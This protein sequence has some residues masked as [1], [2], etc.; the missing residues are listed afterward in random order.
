[1]PLNFHMHHTRERQAFTFSC[2]S[3]RMTST[4]LHN[5]MGFSDS[6][7]NSNANQFQPTNSIKFQFHDT[8][9]KRIETGLAFPSCRSICSWSMQCGWEWALRFALRVL[10]TS[11]LRALTWNRFLALVSLHQLLPS[12]IRVL[13]A[14]SMTSR[15]RAPRGTRAASAMLMMMVGSLLLLDTLLV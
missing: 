8:N 10:A 7:I 6:T 13:M 3:D 14:G 5:H 1:M 11:F 4:Y 15:L 9:S 12:A 2:N